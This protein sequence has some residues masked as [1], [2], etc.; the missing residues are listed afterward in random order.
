MG[1]MDNSLEGAVANPVLLVH[2]WA[3][4]FAH[5]WQRS[6]LVDLLRESGRTVVEYDLPG[7]GSATKSHDPADY[8]NLAGNLLERVAPHGVVDAV[9]FSLGAITLMRALVTAPQRFGTVVF[10]GI[11]D[12][13]FQP[14]DP[15]NTEKIL[16]GL[17]G[18]SAPG[19]VTARVFGKIGNEAGN[20]PRALAA[21][22]RRPRQEP[23]TAAQLG[24]IT[25]PVVVAIGDKDF[26]YPAGVLAAAFVQGRLVVLPGIDHFRTPECF[27]FI[28]LV[29][30]LLA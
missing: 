19:D 30:S 3:G 27:D 15:S 10:A 5:T 8:D 25:N 20:D 1:A 23:F 2:G 21:V 13:V 7:H 18:R 14:H 16:S 6:G 29:M 4:S 26:S 28:D 11:G 24:E 9:G 12:G 22:L 17:E